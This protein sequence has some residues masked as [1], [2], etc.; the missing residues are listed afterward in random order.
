MRKPYKTPDLMPKIKEKI[1]ALTDVEN[2]DELRD[3]LDEMEGYMEVNDKTSGMASWGVSVCV[4]A[5][6]ILII[7]TIVIAKDM[8]VD[9]PPIKL[10]KIDPPP[11]RQEEIKKREL[12]KKPVVPVPHDEKVTSDVTMINELEMPEEVVNETEDPI[13]TNEARGRQDAVSDVEMAS[14]GAFKMI[15][16]GGGGSG[17]FGRPTGGGERRRRMSSSYGPNARAA[18]SMLEAA[19]RWLAIHQSPNG[20]WDSDSYFMNCRNGNQCEPG[21]TS[22]G[23]EDAAMTGYSVLCFLGA[24][25]DHKHMSKWRRNVKKGV[26]ALLAMQK[27]DGLIGERNYEHAVCA[28]ALAEAYGMSNDGNLREPAQRAINIV[29]E[30]QTKDGDGYGLGWDYKRPNPNRMDT[31]VTGWNVMALKS[32]KAAGLDTQGAMEGCKKWFK[33]AWES[34]NPG[35]E[36]LDPYGKSV[37]PYTVTTGGQAKKEHLSFV[38]SLCAVFLGYQSGDK[39]LDTLS[40]DMTDRWFKTGKYK[41]NS[42][43]LYYSTL[44]AFQVGGK[45]WGE[46][47]GNEENGFLPWL[48]ETQYKTEDCH[49]GTWKHEPEKWHGSET[50]PILI[51]CYK[52]FAVEVAFRYLPLAAVKKK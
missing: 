33:L 6:I 4:H 47:W 25:Y 22:A 42:Y 41:N 46:T 37:F 3:E 49:D 2:E 20:Q 24:G 8:A 23:D 15:G 48:I 29:I 18:E 34:A 19:L 31:S 45:H 36:N 30:R 13:V 52:L 26:D 5:L 12:V 21:G 7:S 40:N 1:M 43:A 9:S 14:S 17:V 32:A 38:G 39:E 27:A 35:W 50:S 51:H 16:A 11:E 44:A 10:T 28:M